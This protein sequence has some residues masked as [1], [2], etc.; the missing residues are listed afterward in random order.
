MGKRKERE[1][2]ERLAEQMAKARDFVSL[3]AKLVAKPPE[4][5]EALAEARKELGVLEAESRQIKRSLMDDLAKGMTDPL[6][7]AEIARL[8]MAVDDVISY[9]K[10][11]FSRVHIVSMMQPELR[12]TA[13]TIAA[14][15]NSAASI[16]S[17]A[18]ER[19]E[20]DPAEAMAIADK[21][22]E[23]EHQVDEQVARA[24]NLMIVLCGGGD[25][26]TCIASYRLIEALENL[27]DQLEA[28]ANRLRVLIIVK[29]YTSG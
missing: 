29:S 9:A 26:A 4:G 11:V 5:R 14:M 8:T 7:R 28:V 18:M 23:L 24:E 25:A 19:L 2:I 17:K 6:E 1:A 3:V 20:E 12:R 27:V 16:L 21:V 13:S 10:T 22:E 15:A